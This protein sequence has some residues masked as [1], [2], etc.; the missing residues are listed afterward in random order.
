M[1]ARPCFMIKRLLRI[2]LLILLLVSLAACGAEPTISVPSSPYDAAGRPDIGEFSWFPAATL[3]MPEGAVA[4]EDFSQLTGTWMGYI[5]H[6]TKNWKKESMEFLNFQVYGTESEAGLLADWYEKDTLT[7]I[8]TINREKDKDT[9]Y[10]GY[11]S[12]KTLK[13]SRKSVVITFRYFYELDGRQYAVGE[14]EGIQ[15]DRHT[16]VGMVRP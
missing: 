16:W 4:I 14:I 8:Q 3:G 1:K 7:P 2:G 5:H 12:G 15:N 9:I 11:F 13:V 10:T 6:E